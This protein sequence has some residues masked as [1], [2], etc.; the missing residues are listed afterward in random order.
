MSMTGFLAVNGALRASRTDKWFQ[1][2]ATGL[3][4]R[5]LRFG[6]HA[7]VVNA[8][9]AACGDTMQILPLGDSR[10]LRLE[11]RSRQETAP[12]AASRMVSLISNSKLF[13]LLM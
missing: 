7:L 3:A 12:S 1:L 4:A 6:N 11:P 13:S 8:C 10:R 9:P 5:S 2:P